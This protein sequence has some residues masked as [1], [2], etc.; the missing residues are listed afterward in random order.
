MCRTQNMLEAVQCCKRREW[1]S[2]EASLSWAVEYHRCLSKKI[3]ECCRVKAYWQGVSSMPK[4]DILRQAGQSSSIMVVC[5]LYP[6]LCCLFSSE[7][8]LYTET[9]QICL[10]DAIHSHSHCRGWTCI[11]QVNSRVLSLQVY[12]NREELKRRK[13]NK[14]Q[15]RTWE[16][17]GDVP[18][19]CCSSGQL[20]FEVEITISLLASVS[21]KEVLRTDSSQ[22]SPMQKRC[23]DLLEFGSQRNREEFCTV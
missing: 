11:P 6:H 4:V 22:K 17:R 12:R 19:S 21:N 1:L 18:V 9:H 2:T 10:C 23:M 3:C 8:L 7:F 14:Y 16:I 20:K 5:N 15:L 13:I